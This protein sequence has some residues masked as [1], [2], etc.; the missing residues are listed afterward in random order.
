MAG[1]ARVFPS[2]L[3]RMVA[4]LSLVVLAGCKVELNSKLDEQEANEMMSEL[5]S[6][7]VQVSKKVL[8]DGVTLLVDEAQFSDAVQILSASGFPRRVFSTT[9]EM[10]SD[11]GLVASPL[12]EWARFNYAKAQELAQSISTIP[13]VVKAD[14]HIASS[15]KQ[16][17][18][19]KVSP[20]SASVL[21]QMHEE[22]IT[23]ELIPQIKQLISYSIPDIEFDR[24]GVIVSPIAR[25]EQRT[26]LVTILG[27]MLHPGSVQRFQVGLLSVLVTGLAVLGL[28]LAAAFFLWRRRRNAEEVR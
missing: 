20:P 5:M 28:C 17:A 1:F 10:F 8:K 25:G 6:G 21:I 18:F 16:S 4:V 15:R 14:V 27:V 9:S 11:Q 7:G 22:S 13:G 24:V 26:E 2:R 23:S 12:Q 19:E 3:I